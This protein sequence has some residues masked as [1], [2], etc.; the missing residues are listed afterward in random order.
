MWNRLRLVALLGALCSCAPDVQIGEERRLAINTA[1]PMSDGRWREGGA[2]T[3]LTRPGDAVVDAAGW[4]GRSDATG[5]LPALTS[6]ES[7]PSVVWSSTTLGANW[8]IAGALGEV[9]L[10]R[11][12]DENDATVWETLFVVPGLS[13]VVRS[14]AATN[15][16]SL[17]VVGTYESGGVVTGWSA[18]LEA[19]G[20]VRWERHFETDFQRT[21]TGFVPEAIV[22]DPHPASPSRRQF[23]LVGKRTRAPGDTPAYGLAMT[24]DGDLWDS[25]PFAA[26]GTARG[27]APFELGLT[28]C[29]AFDGAV[30][31]GWTQGGA[32]SGAALT[33]VRLDDRFEL[34]SCLAGANE[35]EL[36]GTIERGNDRIPAVATIDRVTRSLRN[37]REHPTAKRVTVMGGARAL[38]GSITAFGQQREPVRRWRGALP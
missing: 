1:L 2:R 27:V 8:I 20:A 33:E 16:G 25:E 7:T 17:V 10:V 37:V 3:A 22:S 26:N 14:I 34:A 19:S 12:L 36:I 23:W 15:E 29:V 32:L 31:L 5:A 13:C 18:L 4:Y 38:D 21:V 11:A 9:G 30:Q 6:L 28:V 24:F 35:V